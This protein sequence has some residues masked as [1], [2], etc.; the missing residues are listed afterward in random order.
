MSLE[1]EILAGLAQARTA[2][3]KLALAATDRK[4]RALA[5]LADNLRA[6]TDRILG[7]NR[8]DVDRA[9]AAGEASAFVERLTLTPDRIAAIARGVEE[10]AALPDPVG[11]TIARW[12]RPNGLDI[13]Q[14]RVPLGVIAIIYESRPNV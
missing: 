13:R 6:S 10:V 7:A 3:R 1:A 5:A 8:T 4:N 11:E 9:H 14:V 2:A 12:R